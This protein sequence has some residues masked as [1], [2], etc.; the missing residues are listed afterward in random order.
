MHD[1][2]TQLVENKP[3]FYSFSVLLLLIFLRLGWWL[4]SSF[5]RKKT[6]KQFKELE[7]EKNVF[8]RENKKMSSSK[9]E[10]L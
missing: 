4:G 1:Y 7:K 10:K 6:K 5:T 3:A 2:I 8:Q 9:T